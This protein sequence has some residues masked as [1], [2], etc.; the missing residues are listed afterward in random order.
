[1]APSNH[2]INVVSKGQAK[3]SVPTGHQKQ[4]K[5]SSLSQLAI[6]NKELQ[7]WV[8]EPHKQATMETVVQPTRKRNALPMGKSV[9]MF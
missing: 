5:Q 4:V 3:Q 8:P 2:Y 6:K 7:V 9:K 1:M